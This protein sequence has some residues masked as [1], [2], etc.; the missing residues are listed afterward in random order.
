M[1][2][3]LQPNT[4]AHFTLGVKAKAQ[5]KSSIPLGAKVEISHK[6][7]DLGVKATLC[8]A[9]ARVNQHPPMHQLAILSIGWAA[10][11]HPTPDPELIDIVPQSTFSWLI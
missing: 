3:C 7:F 5:L 11:F 9:L 10:F 4:Q 2:G 6:G 1:I 8:E